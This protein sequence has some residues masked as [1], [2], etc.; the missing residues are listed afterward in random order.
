MGGSD[1]I[2]ETGGSAAA[3]NSGADTD[4]EEKG[5]ID[6]NLKFFDEFLRNIKKREQNLPP[7][8]RSKISKFKKEWSRF[9]SDDESAEEETSTEKEDVNPPID[10]VERKSNAT[11]NVKKT[12]DTP[13]ESNATHSGKKV[14]KPTQSS[15]SSGEEEERSVKKKRTKKQRKRKSSDGNDM[16]QFVKIMSKFDSRLVPSLE[17]FSETS[18]QQL[19]DYL[20]RFENYCE[21]SFKGDRN[22]WVPELERHLQDKTLEAMLA[23]QDVNDTY[24]SIKSKLLE[25]YNDFSEIRKKK[26]KRVFET[27]SY[28]PG[29]SLSLYCARLEKLFK[30]AHPSKGVQF[31]QTLLD[32]YRDTLPRK[33]RKSLKAKI[34]DHK[35][36]DE[37]IEWKMIKKWART[38]DAE[39]DLDDDHSEIED[40]IVINLGT[41]TANKSKIIVPRKYAD[42]ATQSISD[43]FKPFNGRVYC[44]GNF[45]DNNRDSRFNSNNRT[46]RQD[47]INSGGPGNRFS[48]PPSRL[49]QRSVTCNH[50]GRYGHVQENCRRMLNQ[51]YRC[52]SSEHY[53]AQCPEFNS[54]S[55]SRSYNQTNATGRS[56]SVPPVD[57]QNGRSRNQYSNQQRRNSNDN[58]RRVPLNSNPLA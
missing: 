45:H 56:Q 19:S 49:M 6:E 3:N 51:C 44:S 25:W 48:R 38:M 54:A 11:K 46:D 24:Q 32:K 12:I 30:I 50:C 18:G 52:G 22:F 36:R 9:F 42:A 58:N 27:A 47:Y 17:K 57:S 40:N 29:E 26:N 21:I 1:P 28:Q 20:I 10:Q 55:D 16:E 39:K 41:E 15:A 2:I 34:C 7:E 35:Y 8:A 23:V 5:I 31:S 43:N 14:T 37:T 33:H 4:N 53:A 13:D